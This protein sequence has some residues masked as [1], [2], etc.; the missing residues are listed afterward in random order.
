MEVLRNNKLAENLLHLALAQGA[1]D[2]HI[3][4]AATAVCAAAYAAKHATDAA[5]G[6]ERYGYCRKKSAA[7]WQAAA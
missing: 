4:P 1:S 7:G 3:E 2:L 6:V 5:E